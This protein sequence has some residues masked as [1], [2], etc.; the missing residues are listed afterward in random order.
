MDASRLPPPI[1]EAAYK[2]FQVTVALRASPQADPPPPPA[3]VGWDEDA[4]GETPSSPSEK[5]PDLAVLFTPSGDGEA[6][7]ESVIRVY[8]HLSQED[9]T[10]EAARFAHAADVFAARARRFLLPAAAVVIKTVGDDLSSPS[11]VPA[12]DQ[13]Q[14]RLTRWLES[15]EEFAYLWRVWQRPSV[16]TALPNADATAPSEPVLSAAQ[17]TAVERLMALRRARESAGSHLPR[18]VLARWSHPLIVGPSGSGKGFAIREAARRLGLAYGRWE[19]GAWN[20]VAGRS[21]RASVEQIERFLAN[22]PQGALVHL[23][24]LDA[25]SSARISAGD[26]NVSWWGSVLAEVER[27]LDWCSERNSFDEQ[28]QPSVRPYVVGS[29]RFS[30]LWGG[31]DLGGPTGANA[32][33]VAD[34][35]ELTGA[36]AAATWIKQEGQ[37][38]VGLL[39]RLTL[40]PLIIGRVGQEEAA[41]LARAVCTALPPALDGMLAEAELAASLAGSDGWRGLARCVEAQLTL[42]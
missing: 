40:P 42:A 31:H 23:A 9:T 6:A 20:I 10:R 18:A 26:S 41:S 27:F 2:L 21:N 33:R 15:W 12:D 30:A 28:A 4:D 38:P 17:T 11:L 19:V 35:E 37:M 29:A 1:K 25:L 36:A 13:M 3:V 8:L 7:D 32:W 24:G 39:G 14:P 22:S 34:D 16:V 5:G